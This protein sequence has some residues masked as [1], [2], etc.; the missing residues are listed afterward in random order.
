MS[1]GLVLGGIEVTD[2]Q[3]CSACEYADDPLYTSCTHE[4]MNRMYEDHAA[5]CAFNTTR[6]RLSGG[7]IG[8]MHV[9]SFKT[10]GLRRIFLDMLL[11]HMFCGPLTPTQEI[12]Y[13]KNPYKFDFLEEED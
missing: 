1:S 8:R 4:N 7:S 2:L 5:L 9:H 13:R 11:L 6:V 12:G 10:H 3:M